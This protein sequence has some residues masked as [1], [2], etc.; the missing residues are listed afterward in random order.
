MARIHITLVGGQ[1]MPIYNGIRHA[2]PDKVVFIYSSQSEAVV[3]RLMDFVDCNTVHQPALDDNSPRAILERAEELFEQFRNDDI[4]LNISGGLKSWSHIFGVFFN[5]KSNASIFYIDQ[6]NIITDFKTMTT[7]QM[8]CEPLS[9]ID[10]L[11]L[12]GNTLDTYDKLSEYTEDDINSIPI[13]RQA[14]K[15]CP[16]GFNETTIA[17]QGQDKELISHKKGE[18]YKR[19]GIIMWN[20]DSDNCNTEVTMTLHNNWGSKKEF[21]IICPHAKKLVFNSGWFE[22][23]VANKLAKWSRSKEVL[24]NCLFKYDKGQAK[25]EIDIIINLDNKLLFVECKTQIS[26][27]TELDKFISVVKTMSGTASKAIFITESKMRPE[28]IAKCNENGIIHFSFA[29]GNEKELFK[30]L[31]KEYDKLN[32]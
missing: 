18:L 12:Y 26:N 29:D 31:N 8:D 9:T 2:K 22:I 21:K 30:I 27:N 19:N 28:T 32:K 3:K 10:Y 13:I 15:F 25:N 16:K 17:L 6:N 5:D 14:R 7:F 23:F 20:I 24:T 11:K 1:P 4:S